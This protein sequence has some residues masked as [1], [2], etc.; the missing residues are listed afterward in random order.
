MA[1]EDD[2]TVR[3]RP[4][5]GSAPPGSTGAPAPRPPARRGA[6]LGRGIA[7]GA[8]GAA[9]VAALGWTAFR[10]AGPTPAGDAPPPAAP[11][12]QQAAVP[13]ARPAEAPVPVLSE[14]EIADHRSAWPTLLRLAENPRVFV[15][16]FPDLASQGAALNRVAAMIEK[17]GLPRD[18]V[19][20]EAEMAVVL[21]RAGE[22]AETYYLGHDYR[23][24][25]LERFFAAAARD[26]MALGEAERWVAAQLE[27]A[28]AEAGAGEVAL[29][30]LA[31]PGAR[32]DEAMRR[33][34]LRHEIGH[35]HD[36]TLPF[37]AAHVRRVWAERFT[38]ADRA[39]FRAFLGR[40]GYDTTNED[41]MAGEMQAY[42]LFTPDERFFSPRLLGLDAA[43]VEAL[44][45]LLRERAPV[46]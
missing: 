19:L 21:A 10:L 35:G 6:G 22:T 32:L 20:A 12:A 2:D 18:R 46:P 7:A 27:R 5:P 26:G 44:R 11:A 31:G 43:R 24:S 36:F 9:M 41:L 34:I 29:I 17:A 38:E 40:E 25:D 30:S 39:A 28:R 23:G 33:A 45:G 4:S 37:Y 42:L 1:A 8:A 16:D 13:A 14:A 3:I 15:L